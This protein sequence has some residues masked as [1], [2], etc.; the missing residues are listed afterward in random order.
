MRP[1]VVALGRGGAIETVSRRRTG[2]CSTATRESLCR[3][4]RRL[5]D[6]SVRPCGNPRPRRTLLTD[7]HLGAVKAV[8]D[9][10]L[11]APGE[12]GW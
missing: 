1:P 7:H 9:D 2:C 4:D 11:A 6:L 12:H 5:A 8:V 10:T 3:R